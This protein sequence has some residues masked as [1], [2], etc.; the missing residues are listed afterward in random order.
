MYENSSEGARK[1][2]SRPGLQDSVH[3]QH[4]KFIFKV[5]HRSNALEYD[6]SADFFRKIDGQGVE[7]DDFDVTHVG[8]CLA[9]QVDPDFEYA[10]AFV[11]TGCD[12]QYHVVKNFG[13]TLDKVSMA[14]VNRIK[15]TRVKNS[16]HC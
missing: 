10:G 12:T 16:G 6:F 9:R 13:G 2:V 4:L 14:V 11:G 1:T 5:G 15:R 3:A 7:T 8:Q